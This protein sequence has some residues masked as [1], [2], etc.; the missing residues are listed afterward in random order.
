VSNPKKLLR[1][2]VHWRLAAPL[3]Q[4]LAA[5][6]RTHWRHVEWEN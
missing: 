5:S 1:S 2:R 4:R 3:M 6:L